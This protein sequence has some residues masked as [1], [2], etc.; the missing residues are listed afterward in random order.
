[1]YND[2]LPEDDMQ[3]VLQQKMKDKVLAIRQDDNYVDSLLRITA[4]K[5]HNRLILDEF[6]QRIQILDETYNK[7][8]FHNDIAQI[9][10]IFFSTISTFVQTFFCEE[11]DPYEVFALIVTLYTSF[12]LS[13]VKY[14]KLEERKESVNNIRHQCAEFL[15]SIQTRNDKLNTWCYDK[16][17]AGGNIDILLEQWKETDSLLYNGLS[18]IIEKKQELTCEFEKIMDTKTTKRILQNIRE[19]D[20]KYKQRSIE[21]T[22]QEDNIDSKTTCLEIKKKKYDNVVFYQGNHE[23]PER[24]MIGTRGRNETSQRNKRTNEVYHFRYGE[25]DN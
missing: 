1:M 5:Q 22:Q 20:V 2:D 13:L 4:Y 15:T 7:Y 23:S 3:A 6:R 12:V 18:D 21:I 11:L 17:W 24:P 25:N 8:R 10:I 19:S 9:S 14:K 16:M